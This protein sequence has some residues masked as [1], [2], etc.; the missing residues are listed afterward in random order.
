MEEEKKSNNII[1]IILVLIIIVA[2]G[3]IAY[4]FISQKNSKKD[5][6]ENSTVVENKRDEIEFISYTETETNNNMKISID[7]NKN[8][9]ITNLMVSRNIP[10]S[11]IDGKVSKFTYTVGSDPAV[12][13]YAITE[14][15][16]LY[17]A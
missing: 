10:V 17:V 6:K 7:S 9:I 12:I 1:I 3:V 2:L 4:M 11:G 16:R 14:D 5:N 8:L 15:G 13:I